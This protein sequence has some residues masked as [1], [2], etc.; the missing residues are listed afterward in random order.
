MVGA[1]A[2]GQNLRAALDPRSYLLCADDAALRD[3][4][5][6][7]EA[8]DPEGNWVSARDLGPPGACSGCCRRFVRNASQEVM[9][10]RL[11]ASPE[12]AAAAAAV[13]A[14]A[15]AAAGEGAAAGAAPARPFPMHCDRVSNKGGGNTVLARVTGGGTGRPLLLME[16]ACPRNATSLQPCY[17][18]CVCYAR[19]QAQVEVGRSGIVR[20]GAGVRHGSYVVTNWQLDE[21]QEPVAPVA[22]SGCRESW[23]ATRD[24]TDL[25][26]D[27]ARQLL[28][29]GL[30]EPEGRLSTEYGQDEVRAVTSYGK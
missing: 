20:F 21:A 2:R 22:L 13:E 15:E 7:C 4:A 8:Q 1:W 5:C 19:P 6:S 28:R 26:D 12:S 10:A 3:L 16:S 9:H 17:G 30:S 11:L 23:A 29:L 25:D 14:A 24:W 18:A 27:V